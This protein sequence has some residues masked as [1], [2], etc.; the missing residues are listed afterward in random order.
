MSVT[1]TCDIVVQANIYLIYDDDGSITSPRSLF[2]E[3]RAQGLT[4]VHVTLSVRVMRVC[5]LYCVL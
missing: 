5:L 4:E 2:G 1:V 3:Q